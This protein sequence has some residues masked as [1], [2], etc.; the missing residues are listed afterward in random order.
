MIRLQV[1]VQKRIAIFIGLILCFLIILCGRY[2]WLQLVQG[3]QLAERVKAQSGEQKVLQSPRGTIYDRNGRELAVSMLTKSLFVDPSNVKDGDQLAADLAPILMISE[4]EIKADIAQ[5]GGF[6]WIKRRLEHDESEKV[7]KLIDEQGLNCLGF[8]EES[9]RYY[10]NDMLAAN[11]IGFVGT[12]DLG[13]DGIEQ[14]FNSVMKGESKKQLLFTDM[15]ARPIFDSIFSNRSFKGDRCKDVYLT[16]DSTMQFIVEQ[17]LDKAVIENNPRAVTAIV[18]NPQTGEILAMASRPSYNPNKFYDYKAADWK[19]KAVS[20]VYE[21]GSTFKA[22]VAAA[23]LQENLVTPQQVFVDPGYVMVSGRRIQNWSADSFGTVTFLDVVKQSINT[24]FVQVGLRV[25]AE[26]LTHYAKLFGFGQ[27]TGVELPGEEQGILFDPKDMRDSD[28]ATMSIGQSIAVTPLQLVTAMSA[29]ANNGVL[30]K[31][32]ILKAVNNA[33]GSTY[34]QTQTDTVRR[35]IDQDTDTTLVGML[36]Q[37]VASG[38]GGKAAVKGYRIAGKTGTAQKIRDDS[39]GYMEGHYIASFCGFAP[40]ENPQI[41]VLV[42]IDD[43][44]GIYYG[45]QIAAPIAKEIFSQLFRYLN[46]APSSDPL[47]GQPKNAQVEGTF[48]ATAIPMVP[49]GKIL[50]P[51][52][53]GKSLRQVSDELD[54]LGL[55]MKPSGTGIAVRQS[56]EPNTI[57]DQHTELAVYFETS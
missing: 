30:L 40:V 15:Q 4:A 6:V 45:G 47:A 38:G 8:K 25:G 18:M 23:A 48:P 13:L 5:G 11:V 22:V 56:I 21:P 33:D 9:K 57:V 16:L 7:Q 29:I 32:H 28:V 1:N 43:P 24:G 2:A 42:M 12:D 51:D 52:M 14:E 17:T 20:F 19:N 44:S 37:V 34:A 49:Q 55:V 27:P 46:I 10:P 39:R 50:V 53:T 3:G 26:K 35:V 54:G 36:E 31:P 41:T